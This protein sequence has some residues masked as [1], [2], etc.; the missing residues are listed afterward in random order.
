VEKQ[1][2]VIRIKASDDVMV[3]SV[4][5]VVLD[6]KGK[7]SGKGRGNK[8]DCWEHVPEARVVPG[9]LKPLMDWNKIILK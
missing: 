5:V 2:R 7:V 3:A 4:Q 1:G 9:K 8:G 6:E